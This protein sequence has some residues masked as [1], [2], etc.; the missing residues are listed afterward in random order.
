MNMEN[1]EKNSIAELVD[2]QTKLQEKM[3]SA[4]EGISQDAQTAFNEIVR[5]NHKEALVELECRKEWEECLPS[6]VNPAFSVKRDLPPELVNLYEQERELERGL[7]RR[8]EA[9]QALLDES[10]NTKW[11][12]IDSARRRATV[13]RQQFLQKKTEEERVRAA[14]QEE[15]DNAA[16]RIEKLAKLLEEM[17]QRKR[18][19]EANNVQQKQDSKRLDNDLDRLV[20]E[21]NA[22]K[23]SNNN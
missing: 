20:R 6:L 4:I 16:E 1:L 8:R 14:I 21:L 22:L 18:R 2:E 9:I 10:A 12:D 13:L 17:K 11:A 23:T 3:H 7:H 15:R 5:S 19:L